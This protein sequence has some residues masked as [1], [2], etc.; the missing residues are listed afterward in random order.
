MKKIVFSKIEII[1]LLIAWVGVSIA[2]SIAVG[3]LSFSINYLVVLIGA[4]L[5][6]GL[7]FLLHE[8][9]HKILA[10]KYGCFAEFRADF[11]MLFISIGIAFLGFLFAAPG[12][13]QIFGRIDKKKYAVISASGPAANLLL[14]LIFLG[15]YYTINTSQIITQFLLNGFRFNI[16]LGFFNLLPFPSFDG[17]KIYFGDKKLYFILAGMAFLLMLLQIIIIT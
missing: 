10:N 8:I 17:I 2:F 14:S 13:V 7:G 4:M 1:H 3:G 12:A 5:S 15:L 16:F 6:I 11:K 9:A